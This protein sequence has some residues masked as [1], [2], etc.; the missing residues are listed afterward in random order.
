MNGLS[1]PVR[2]WM[3]RARDDLAV[4][5]LVYREDYFSHACFL[6]QQSIEKALK[7]YLLWAAHD[8]P[9]V[10]RLAELAARCQA[11]DADFEALL[12]DCIVVDQYYVPTR[13]P[14]GVPSSLPGGLPGSEEAAEAVA[15][16]AR[17]FELV[18][19]KLTQ[20]NL[21]ES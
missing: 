7:G 17:A 13:Y 16:A 2:Q 14:N 11:H 20:G 9:R 5:R 18:Q 10:H 3:R 8:Y 19:N 12:A 21:P 4:A 6:S 1:E 15:I